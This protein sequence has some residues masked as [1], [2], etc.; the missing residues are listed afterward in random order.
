MS[1]FKVGDKVWCQGYKGVIAYYFSI[2]LIEVDWSLF[3]TLVGSEDI[4]TIIKCYAIL[5]EKK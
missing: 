3:T 2:N 5:G 1:E 4:K